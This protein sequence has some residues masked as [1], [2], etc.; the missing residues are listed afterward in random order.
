MRATWS[1]HRTDG[2]PLLAAQQTPLAQVA[3]SGAGTDAMPRAVVSATMPAGLRAAVDVTA[4]RLSDL[5]GT[6]QVSL[7]P[8]DLF[9]HLTGPPA[10]RTLALP[11]E[12]YPVAP[13]PIGVI[14]E[15][16]PPAGLG[17]PD[18][19]VSWLWGGRLR[20][21]HPGVRGFAKA[22]VE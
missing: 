19:H 5:P 17:A 4:P 14:A 15:L 20:L 12:L 2:L 21:F 6:A 16:A 22:G 18:L 10:T 11:A 7:T 3:F 13:P 8:L 1:L 9:G